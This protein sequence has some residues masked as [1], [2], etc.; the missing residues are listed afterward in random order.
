MLFYLIFLEIESAFPGAVCY[1][2]YTA[3]IQIA[4]T[5]E[6]NILQSQLGSLTG[7]ST[8]Y[9]LALLDLVDLLGSNVLVAGRG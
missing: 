9:Q 6:S 7:N 5:I 4:A 1:S 2:L 3:V 8:A